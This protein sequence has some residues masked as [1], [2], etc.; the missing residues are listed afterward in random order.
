MKVRGW[1]IS[2]RKKR[3][4]HVKIFEVSP[5]LKQTKYGTT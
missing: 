5:S 2:K 1:F 3:K 4:D